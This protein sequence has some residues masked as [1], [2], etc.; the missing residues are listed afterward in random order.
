M[1]YDIQVLKNNNLPE[2]LVDFLNYLETIKS[3]SINTI[4]GYRIDLTI[5]FRFMMIYKGKVNSDSVEFEDID[6]SVIDDEFLRGIKLRDLYAFLSFTEKYRDNSSYARARKVATLKSF[7]K[8]LFG[9]AKVITENPALEL[10]SPKINKRHPVYLTL[11]QSIHLLESLNKNDKNYS[12]DYCILMFFLNCGM[13]LSELCSIQID[14][15]RDDTLTIIGKGNKERTVY[16]NDACLKALANYLN[17]RDD[18]KALLDNKKFLFLSSR[19][20]PINKRT[21]EIMIKKHITNAGLT[22]DKYTPH[23][24]RHTAATLMYKYGNVDIRSLQSILGHTNI[25]TTQIYTHVDD[26]SLR[27]AVKSNPLSKL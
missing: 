19:N 10:E 12:R 4:D 23:K 2:S 13:R 14:K 25:S 5:F 16:L 24:L 1:K 21:V 20:G 18:S 7:F 27:D 15:I 26:D 17:V 11:N 9:K 6:I 22:D 3:T 8:F